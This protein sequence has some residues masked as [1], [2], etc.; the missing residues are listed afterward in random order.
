MGAG[1]DQGGREQ[2][3]VV[4][5]RGGVVQVHHLPGDCVPAGDHPLPPHFLLI[6]HG[7]K[8]NLEL[9]TQIHTNL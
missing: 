6:M 7:E 8:V 9:L 5:L 1:Q 2:E 4:G 3:G